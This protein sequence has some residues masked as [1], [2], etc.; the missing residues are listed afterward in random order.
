MKLTLLAGCALA[1]VAL[2]GCA[3]QG[4]AVLNDLQGC[5]RHYN[6][7][8]TSGLAG[9]TAPQFTGSVDIECA[10]G[11]TTGVLIQKAPETSAKPAAVPAPVAPAP[12]AASPPSFD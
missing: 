1:C 4:A 8:V 12:V 11:I 2:S 7:A 5:H 9:L 10:A 6:G 3:S